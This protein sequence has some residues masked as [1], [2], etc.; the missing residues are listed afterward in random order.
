MAL[1]LQSLL[2]LMACSNR[3]ELARQVLYLKVENQILRS[4][5]P[6]RVSLTPE[7]RA[8]LRKFGEPLG[9]AIK[10]LISIVHPKTFAR[11]VREAAN[12]IPK[13]RA[14][15]G[16]P[17]T[18]AEIA[19]LIVRIA[20]QTGWG[21]SRIK[22]ELIKLNCPEVGRTTIQNVLKREGCDP[23]PGRGPT[24]W[25]DFMAR[26]AKTL[27]AADFLT[28]KAWTRRGLVDLYLLTFIHIDSRRVWVSPCTVHPTGSWV[29]Q[30]ARNFLMDVE[31]AGLEAGRLIHDRDGKFVTMFDDIL[32]SAGIEVT[33]LPIRSPNLN[34]H[35]ERFVQTIKHECLSHFVI[36]GHRHLNYLVTEFVDYY[37]K[38]RPHQSKGNR[39]LLKLAD[40]PPSGTGEI[41]CQERLGGLLKHYYR[42][43]A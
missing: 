19:R 42:K 38:Q 35:M 21:Y 27:W 43:A 36:L 26:H 30:Q 7:E 39:P 15:G 40:D 22:G 6:K 14:K 13:P 16:R 28:V 11:W 2:V 34:A 41:A 9:S 17:R 37:H 31:D 23:G 29:C 1:F 8:R 18:A 25:D 10:E 32:N 4:K 12:H 24:T 20:K 33:K 5:L 3:D